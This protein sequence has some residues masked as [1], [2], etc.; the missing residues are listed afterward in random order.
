M[1]KFAFTLMELLTAMAIIGI[2]AAL[3]APALTNIMPDKTKMQVIK[4]HKVLSDITKDML[5][6][7]Y[8]YH[9][10]E[11]K[12][13]Y[14]RVGLGAD[15]LDSDTEQFPAL[16]AEVE[17]SEYPG[18]YISRYS[19]AMKYCAVAAKKMETNGDLGG[20]EME[21]TFSTIDGIYW[22]FKPESFVKD[23]ESKIFTRNYEVS[24]NLNND[25]IYGD[26]GVASSENKKPTKFKFYVDGY[27]KVTG[28][29]SDKL[30]IQYLKTRTKLNNKKADYKAAF[31][32]W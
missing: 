6:D 2:T 24:I 4:V 14:S 23:T 26:S 10:Y 9:D 20:D 32:K 1:K 17:S 7:P 12:N 15:G 8:Y 21:C 29:P 11:D 28:H 31:G 5:N 3:V 27:G 25:D 13:E 22:L 18:N 16:K 19:G 30:T